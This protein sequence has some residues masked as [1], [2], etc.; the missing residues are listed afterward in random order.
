VG[1]GDTFLYMNLREIRQLI[2][3]EPVELDTVQ[4]RLSHCH[5]I[6]DLR[7]SAK[8]LIPRPVF[9]YVDGAADEE[10]SLA[11]NTAAFRRYRFRPRELVDVGGVDTSTQILGRPASLPLALAPTGYSRMMHPDGEAAVARAAARRNLPYTLSTM[12]TTSIEDVAAAAH[13]VGHDEIWY[14]LYVMRNMAQTRDMVQRAADNGYK[15]LTVTVD[16]TFLGF[17]TRDERNGLIIPPQLTARTIASIGSRPAYWVRMLRNPAITFAN[18]PPSEAGG[19]I[20]QNVGKFRAD[21]TWDYLAELRASWPGQL[22]VKGPLGAAD[23]RRAV[24]AG[25]DGIQLSNHGGRQLDQSV[26]PIDLVAEV[27]EAVGPGPAVLI[28]SGI[29]HGMDLAIAVA[30]GADAGLVGRAYLYGLMAGGEPGVDRAL[31]ILATQFERT[32]QLL[33]VT[34][35]AELRKEGANL[36]SRD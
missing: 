23:A 30:L 33:G 14:Q 20:D 34:S 12:G 15:V 19:A 22:L 29:R 10:T 5:S 4:R 27:R 35:V 11:A 9:D 13:A 18:F 6:G 26:A 7:R 16:T 2:Q 28:D 31:E 21:I 17:R 8:R 25:A 3:M 24:E 32:M 36:L 1:C